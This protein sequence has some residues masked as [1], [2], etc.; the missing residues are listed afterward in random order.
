MEPP[1]AGMFVISA[2]DAF[3][4]STLIV[5]PELEFGSAGMIIFFI[6]FGDDSCVNSFM[7]DFTYPRSSNFRRM[8]LIRQAGLSDCEIINT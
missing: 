7:T 6:S 3:P 2:V 5:D 4:V 8:A 1:E